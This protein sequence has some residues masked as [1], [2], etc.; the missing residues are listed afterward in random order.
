MADVE[1]LPLLLENMDLLKEDNKHALDLFNNIITQL[2]QDECNSIDLCQCAK[3]VAAFLGCGIVEVETK[4]AETLAELCKNEAPR[5]TLSNNEVI[6][7]LINLLSSP[8]KEAKN[9]ACRAIGNICFDNNDARAFV[10]ENNGLAEIVEVLRSSSLPDCEQLRTNAAG[11]LLNVIMA[12]EYVY[13][14]VIEMGVMEVLYDLLTFGVNTKQ[15]E[16]TAIHIYVILGLLTDTGLGTVCLTEKLCE[17]T[18]KVLAEST[19][20]ELSELCVELL[21]TQ[22]ENEDVRLHLA[23]AGLCELLI[24]LLEKHGKLADDDETRNLLKMACDLIVIILNGDASMEIAYGSG[25]GK[26]FE[27][28]VNWLDSSDDD[29]Q[30]TAVL[31]MANFAR[32]DMH[33][34]QM[35]NQGVSRKLLQLLEQN[36]TSD[37]KIRLQHALLSAL[38]NLV[39]PAVNKGTVLQQG[40]LQHIYPMFSIPTFPVVFKLLG[41]LRMVIDGQPEA[42]SEL[43]SKEEIIDKLVEWCFTDDHPGVQGEANRLLAWIVKNS[44]DRD[45]IGKMV[46]RGCVECLVRM[47][48]AEHTV[49]QAEAFLALN[50]MTAMRGQDA[51]YSLLRASVGSAITNFLQQ[52]TPPREVFHNLLAFVGQLVT[53]SDMRRHL[54][55]TG[56]PKALYSCVLGDTLSDLRDQVSRLTTLIDA[57]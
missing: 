32:T 55:D 50:L 34:I 53:S 42:A 11:C 30:V 6:V 36:N 12:Q 44:R 14:K 48:Q 19:N 9:Q 54:R 7:P 51:E 22:A 28:L 21:H 1:K 16:E 52:A 35:V 37:A 29:L 2:D 31:A 47:L 18:V 15:S 10:F 38:R 43:G 20:G 4:A 23:K 33:C 56:V 24:E 40:L 8:C 13:S 41:S 17:A 25:R 46:G 39:I 3:D 57:G 45:V 5:S 49:M 27:G 26:V